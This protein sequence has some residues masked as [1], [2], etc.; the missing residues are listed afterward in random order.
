MVTVRFVLV[1][2]LENRIIIFVGTRKSPS[3]RARGSPKLGRSHFT[4]H[5]YR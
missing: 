4:I 2:E 3:A 5:S 1:A